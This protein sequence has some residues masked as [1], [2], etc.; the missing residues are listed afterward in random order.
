MDRYLGW[1]CFYSA[2]LAAI[3]AGILGIAKYRTPEG[4]KVG[5]T[6]SGVVLVVVALWLAW[7]AITGR[8]P[9]WIKES[10]DDPS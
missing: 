1:G 10:I 3:G 9:D 6:V 5:V 8:L 4:S 7:R 2:A